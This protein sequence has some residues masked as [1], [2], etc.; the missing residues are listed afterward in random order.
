LGRPGGGPS[1]EP[2]KAGMGAGQAARL[3]TRWPEVLKL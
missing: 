1:Q 3:L 2:L